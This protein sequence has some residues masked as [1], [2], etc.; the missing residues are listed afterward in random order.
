LGG[1]RQKELVSST[2]WAFQP[3]A[4][5]AQDALELREEHFD[6]LPFTPRRH[7]SVGLGDFARNVSSLFVD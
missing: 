3:E 5:E 4:V 7:V 6:L 1:G 2:Q